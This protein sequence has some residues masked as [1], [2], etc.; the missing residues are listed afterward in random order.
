MKYILLLAIVFGLFYSC[1]PAYK[2]N[3]DKAAFES[4]AVTRSFKSVADMNDSYFELK[5]NHF[6]EFYRQLFDSV[7]NTVYPGKYEIKG[8]TL[9]L[10]FYDKKGKALLGSKAI[11]RESKNEIVFFK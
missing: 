10:E 7:K 5:E 3:R 9:H 2:F 1:S 6:F 8:D 4:S 11:I